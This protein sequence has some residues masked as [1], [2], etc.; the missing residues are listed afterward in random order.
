MGLGYSHPHSEKYRQEL[1]KQH[2]VVVI[3]DLLNAPEDVRKFYRQIKEACERAGKSTFLPIEFLDLREL[4]RLDK[5]YKEIMDLSLG[6]IRRAGLVVAY[7]GYQGGDPRKIPGESTMDMG[8][9]LGEA[10]LREK[11]QVFVY[12]EE[13]AEYLK[14][15]DPKI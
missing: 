10:K 3:S 6:K 11:S 14:R 12:E 9:M 7:I 8:K 1:A 5:R 2:E 13:K 15:T 4:D